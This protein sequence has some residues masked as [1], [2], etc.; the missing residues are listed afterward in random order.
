MYVVSR[1]HQQPYLQL[2]TD[3][4]HTRSSSSVQFSGHLAPNLSRPASSPMHGTTKESF[5]A[6][7]L[8]VTTWSIPNKKN[9]R[10]QRYNQS[11]INQIA[12]SRST[13]HF[14]IPVAR[15]LIWSRLLSRQFKQLRDNSFCNKV[16]TA[17]SMHLLIYVSDCSS[18]RV[19]LTFLHCFYTQ[20]CFN[21]R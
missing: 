13:K 4:I 5:D 8:L 12:N 9:I 3:R 10:I 6:Y 14:F 7:A 2:L 11:W 20:P 21:C 19:G 17:N 16:F 15:I 1:Q 18:L